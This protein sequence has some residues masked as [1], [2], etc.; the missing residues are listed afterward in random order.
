MFYR[1]C[2]LILSV[3]FSCTAFAQENTVNKPQEPILGYYHLGMNFDEYWD[4][5]QKMKEAT[6]VTD[7]SSLLSKYLISINGITFDVADLISPAAGIGGT[8]YDNY[9]KETFPLFFTGQTY[10]LENNLVS[11][12]IKTPY[13]D[14]NDNL[15]YM[16]AGLYEQQH[17]PKNQCMF[18]VYN[19]ELHN[20]L[21]SLTE[22]LESYLSKKYGT[23]TKEYPIAK[24][25]PLRKKE[26][27]RQ[28]PVCWFNLCYSG[29][30]LP[31]AEWQTGNMKVIMGITNSATIFISFLD[32]T[33]LSHQNLDR[34]FAPADQSRPIVQW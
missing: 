25:Q 24:L 11:V 10:S 17:L 29:A 30:I 21:V 34:I 14:I 18:D 31:K 26:L 1:Y 3:L 20:Q 6:E 7:S 22:T 2:L 27:F 33:L 8:D 9:T 4:Q 15:C 5:T 23:P 13:Y 28:L 16:P 19:I 32:E 12:T